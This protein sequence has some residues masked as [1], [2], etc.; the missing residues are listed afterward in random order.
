M[1]R[2]PSAARLQA[3]GT[4]AG[5]GGRGGRQPL[6]HTGPGV[7]R[8]KGFVA[9][10]RDLDGATP[11]QASPLHHLPKIPQQLLPPPHRHRQTL[12]PHRLPG[13]IAIL[14]LV[15]PPHRGSQQPRLEPLLGEAQGWQRRQGRSP[16]GW[17]WWRCMVAV[18]VP[19]L[20]PQQRHLQRVGLHAATAFT[21]AAVNSPLS[22]ARR[23]CRCTLERCRPS[24]SQ[25][26]LAF[27]P[28]LARFSTRL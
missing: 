2:V 21:S 24:S 18:W 23:R 4:P 11:Q 12:P 22:L 3:P 8:A 16:G 1:R 20:Y 9:V 14:K 5:L 17:R 19:R 13:R 27:R 15:A 10:L 26:S 7:K 6:R 28:S 25:M